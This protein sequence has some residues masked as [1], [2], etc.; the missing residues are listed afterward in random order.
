MKSCN[1]II[2]FAVCNLVLWPV[3]AVTH[4]ENADLEQALEEAAK[5]V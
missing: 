5:N 2:G 3:A 1:T 4:A